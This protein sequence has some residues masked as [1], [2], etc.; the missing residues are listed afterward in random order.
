[1]TLDRLRFGVDNRLPKLLYSLILPVT[2]LDFTARCRL[3]LPWDRDW[4]GRKE[5]PNKTIKIEMA[6]T[7]I[8][9]ERSFPYCR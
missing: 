5:L 1:M 8:M 4:E 2:G 3:S 9:Q 6:S 7:D